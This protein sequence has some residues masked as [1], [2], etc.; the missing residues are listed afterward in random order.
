MKKQPY[1]VNLTSPLVASHPPSH[2]ALAVPLAC[3]LPSPAPLSPDLGSRDSEQP[4]LED[5]VASVPQRHA[6]A[7]PALAVGDA[8]EAVL[9]PAVGARPGLLVTE[10]VPAE[11]VTRGG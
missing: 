2:S 5:R 10:V 9:T 6:E 7:E 8:Q 3:P 1:K 4:L 11:G